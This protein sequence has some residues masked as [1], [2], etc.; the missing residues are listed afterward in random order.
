[1][2]FTGIGILFLLASLALALLWVRSNRQFSQ[3]QKAQKALLLE[4]ESQSQNFMQTQ[5]GTK[6]GLGPL[7]THQAS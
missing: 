3:W 2:I 1:M 7:G 5:K 6:I 4:W